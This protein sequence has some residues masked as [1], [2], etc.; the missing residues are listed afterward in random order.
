MDLFGTT[1]AAQL[2]DVPLGSWAWLRKNRIVPLGDVTVGLRR[3]YTPHQIDEMRR[4]ID[5]SG[6]ERGRPG[7]KRE[8]N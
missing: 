5:E 7:R 4:R 6:Y 2:L 1:K 8:K 3:Y